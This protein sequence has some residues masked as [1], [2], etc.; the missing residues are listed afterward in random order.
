MAVLLQHGYQ[1]FVQFG[2]KCVIDLVAW[3][4]GKTFTISVKS[5]ACPLSRYGA[6]AAQ[7]RRIRGVRGKIKVH[8]FDPK[9]C[10]VLA[11]YIH[12]IDKVC[13]VKASD[14]TSA[15]AV[16]FRMSA[17]SFSSARLVQDFCDPAKVMP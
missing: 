15:S 7:L 4:D 6:Y 13:F 17:S 3:K 12:E 1:V 14:V 10:D 9:S 16:A 11:V 2:G 5:V 8:P